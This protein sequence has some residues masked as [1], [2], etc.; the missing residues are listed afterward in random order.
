LGC[1]HSLKGRAQG[2]GY[3]IKWGAIG[4]MLRNTLGTSMLCWKPIENLIGISWEH[5]ENNKKPTPPPTPKE[6]KT[7]APSVHATSPHCLQ[8]FFFAYLYLSSLPFLAK[9]NDKGMNYGH[10]F[11]TRICW[12]YKLF[13]SYLFFENSNNKISNVAFICNNVI[14]NNKN[15][16]KSN[17]V[18]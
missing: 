2:K 10:T 8:E 13:D 12:V 18:Y 15:M 5:V 7:W 4:N 6:T 11:N 3:E 9:V 16:I 17:N 1:L 14:W